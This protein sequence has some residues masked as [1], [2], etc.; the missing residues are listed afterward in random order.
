MVKR[1]VIR[2]SALALLAVIGAVL[3]VYFKPHRNV[4]SEQGIPVKAG[5]LFAAYSKNERQANKEFLDKAIEVTGE[6]G[7]IKTNQ[8]GK[9]VVILKTADPIFGVVCT[10]RDTL[11]N[12]KNGNSVVVK[13]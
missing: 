6:I 3:Y 10:F 12:L 1:N 9:S 8:E 11:A 13:G 2:V 5:D 4:E 7:D